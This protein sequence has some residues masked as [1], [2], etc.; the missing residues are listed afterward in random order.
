MRS[1]IFLIGFMGSGKSTVGRHLA[2]HLGFRFIDTDVFIETRFRERITDI[3]ARYGEETF[4]RRERMAIEELM[5]MPETI[6][7]TGGGLPCQGDTMDLL[8]EAGHTIYLRGSAPVLASRLELCKR[9]RPTIRDKSGG[10]LLDFVKQS[11]ERRAPIY[12]RA[13]AIY[14]I[15]E[16]DTV[17]KERLLAEEIARSLDLG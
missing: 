10:E 7:A 13:H 3:F 4:R 17:A 2:D 5:S 11:L 14:D 6:F 15:D 8:L 9:T 1:P 12:S 16:V